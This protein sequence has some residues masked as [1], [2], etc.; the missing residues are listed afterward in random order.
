[1][2]TEA[3]QAA[4]MID[5]YTDLQRIANAADRDR[6]I[7]NQMKKARAKLEALGVVVDDLQME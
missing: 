2:T 4:V 3:Q 7:R 6:E 1:M 5:I